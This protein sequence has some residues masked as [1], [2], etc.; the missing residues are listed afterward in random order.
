MENEKSIVKVSD[1]RLPKFVEDAYDTI[2][3]MKQFAGMLLDS[4]LVPDHFYEKGADNKPDYTKGK[5]PA[6]VVVLLQAQQLAIPPMTALQHV[7]PVSGLLSIKGDLAKT[8]IFASGKLKKDSWKETVTGSI[9][10]ENMV[11]SITATREDNGTTLTRTFSV[12]KAK[13]MGLWITSSQV[14]GQDGWKWKKSA[15]YKTPDRMLNYR[16]LGNIAR[17]LFSDVLLNMYTTEEAQDIGKET[18]EIIETESGAKITIPDKEHAKTRSTKMTDRVVDK[19]PNNKFGKVGDKNIQEAEV[20]PVDKNEERY[21]ENVRLARESMDKQIAENNLSFNPEVE[22]MQHKDDKSRIME[23]YS[24]THLTKHDESPFKAEKGSAESINGVLVIRDEAG[25]ITNQEEIDN[26]GKTPAEEIIDGQWTLKQMEAMDT[27]ILLKLVMEDMDMMESCEIIGGKNT[28]KKLREIVFAHQNENLAEY[29]APYLKANEEREKQEAASAVGKEPAVNTQAGEIPV[30]KDFD[31]GKEEAKIDA[32]LNTTK[33]AEPEK[34]E[35][36]NKYDIEIPAET[37]R[38]F[39]L[40]KGLFNKLMG[41]TP[42]ITT[43]RFMELHDKLKLPSSYC[44]K[45]TFLKIASVDEIN[46]LLNAN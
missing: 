35:A 24:V 41:V 14:S 28:N 18:T 9:E 27:P 11:V 21:T 32:F 10:D 37:P 12:D 25:N 22:G 1:V 13:R 38:D 5:V 23:N 42:Q 8:M 7:I 3:G 20:I 17:D 45:E 6:V 15:W 31:K 43:P 39:S 30:N 26:D 36:G 16:A 34:I 2:E 19:I 33:K 29:V 40:V 44:D 46:L 4:K